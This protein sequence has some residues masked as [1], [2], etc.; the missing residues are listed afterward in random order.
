MADDKK[1]VS[2]KWYYN[3]IWIIVAILAVGP[4]ALPLVWFS[5]RLKKLHKIILTV[6]VIAATIW[7]VKVT[8]VIYQDVLKQVA[9]LQNALQ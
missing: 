6:L 3:P 1:P 5:P 8:I 7:F 9:D 2:V 4:F